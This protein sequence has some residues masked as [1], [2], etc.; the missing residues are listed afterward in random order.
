[1]QKIILLST[2]LAILFFISFT[3]CKK[4]KLLTDSNA[5]LEFSDDTIAFDTVF[6]S[7]GSA[8]EVFVVRNTYDQPVNI[9]SLYI[10]SGEG[11]NYRLNVN[12]TPG[13]SFSDVEIGANDSIWIFVEVTVD[14]NS[15]TTPLIVE[16]A[17]VFN[18][19]GHQ[20][21]VILDAYG[22]DAHFFPSSDCGEEKSQCTPLFK[23][24]NCPGGGNQFHWTNDKPYVIY[25]YAILDAGCTLTIDAGVR[26][27]FHTNSGL[28]ITSSA[29]LIVNGTKDNP[30]T[31]E[32]DRLGS[33]YK[34]VPGQ[35]D[36]I[37]FSNIDQ[38]D[39]APCP[40][41]I[42][43]GPGSKGSI[44]DYAIIKNGYV[45]IQADTFGS[46]T[47]YVVEINNT[48]IKNFASTAFYGNG[49]FVSA[50]NSVFAN[51]GEFLSYL[52]IG[53]GYRFLHCTFANYWSHSNRSTPS[54]VVNDYY[55]DGESVLHIRP[56]TAYFGNCIVYGNQDTEI[57]FDTVPTGN[58]VTLIMNNC[59][60]KIDNDTYNGNMGYYNQ[61]TKDYRNQD[62][63]FKDIDNN[64]YKTDSISPA[65]N[66]G[67]LTITNTV[68]VCSLDI[69][70][71]HRPDINSLIPDIGAYED[72]NQ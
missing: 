37:W 54:M 69:E 2:G 32:G 4:E 22:Q 11:S 12:G 40:I 39:L 6:T 26:V 57:G 17:I 31:F 35:W 43:R 48:I 24:K 68:P 34:D 45:G 53:G 5:T 21:H 56:I 66:H 8:T 62:P 1:M 61:V 71:N 58:Y 18:T 59:L 33:D 42:T 13:K 29:Q 16:D 70:G 3:A 55:V 30:V 50:N 63:N 52:S 9:S 27:H 46:P 28:I 65:F 41:E 15:Q 23:L 19:N 67:D 47:D 38:I 14:P 7:V 10:A 36:R 44:V 72:D 25:G 20:Q 49:S 60:M 51:C 64:Y